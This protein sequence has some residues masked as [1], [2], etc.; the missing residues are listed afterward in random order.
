MA[1]TLSYLAGSHQVSRRGLEEIAE[2][3]FG[4][5]ISLGTID[6]L[7]RR[8]SDALADSHAEALA[9]VREAEVKNVDETGWKIAGKRCWLWLAATATVAAFLIHGRRSKEALKELLGD[10]IE[11]II[12]T[13]RWSAYGGHP[14]D[15]RQICWAHLKRDFQKQAEGTGVGKELGEAGLKAVESLF[16]EWERFRGGGVSREEVGERMRPIREELQK[17]LQR[18]RGC[19]EKGVAAF[20]GNVLKVEEGLW[21]FVR[22]EGVEPTNNH[23]E[24]LLRRGVLWRKNSFGSRSEEGC[25]LVERMLTVVQTL[26]L[27]SRQVLPFLA[28]SIRALRARQP[29][30]ILLPAH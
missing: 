7:Q 20:C 16:G 8:T 21:T 17:A 25:R 13:D 5:P 1:A 18:G 22:V 12:G 10:P 23:A 27:Q 30:P 19:A 3:V 15:R 9:E 28:N 6:A 29:A 14:S 2:Q 11:G 26:R 24:R 4:V